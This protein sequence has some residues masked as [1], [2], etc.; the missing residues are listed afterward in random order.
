MSATT[1]NVINRLQKQ[2]PLFAALGDE[3]R[4]KLLARLSDGAELS[5]TQLSQRASI[6]R[7]AITKH[8]RVLEEAGLVKGIRRGRENLFHFDPQPLRDARDSLEIISRQWDDALARL[9]AFVEPASSPGPGSR[10]G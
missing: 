6:T 10:E 3:V 1:R 7:Q 8:L 5:I 2:A 9:K 4:L